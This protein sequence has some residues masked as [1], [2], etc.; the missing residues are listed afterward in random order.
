MRLRSGFT[1]IELLVVIAIIAI[2]AAILFPVFAQAR[3]KA[4]QT[5]CLSNL[6]QLAHAYQMYQT[7]YDEVLPLG[8]PFLPGNGWLSG[9]Y[10]ETPADWRRDPVGEAWIIEAFRSVWVNSLMVY[11]KSGGILRCP[12]GQLQRLAGEGIAGRPQPHEASYTYNAMLHSLP[13]AQVLHPAHVPAFWEGM[14][15]V[16]LLGLAIGNPSLSCPNPNLP[17]RYN[18]CPRD[19]SD[20][21]PRGLAFRPRATMWIHSNGASFVFTDGH[22][23]W[24]R[25]GAHTGG[26][27]TD[28]RIDPFTRYNSQGIPQ[29]FWANREGCEHAWLF[30]PDFDPSE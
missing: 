18:G 26:V 14:G 30:R 24:R 9:I 17:C 4:R 11:I 8:F 28:Y 29:S 6:R 15:K 19:G 3:E 25:L 1:L 27:N 20:A 21:Y 10:V 22:V 5:Q 7:D 23:K 12:S 2:L 16:A 13:L